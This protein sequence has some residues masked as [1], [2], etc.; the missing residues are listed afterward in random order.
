M[1]TTQ[2]GLGYYGV[3]PEPKSVTDNDRLATKLVFDRV[4][5]ARVTPT[6]DRS[7]QGNSSSGS[8]SNSK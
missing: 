7:S 3:A 2:I 5:R 8:T 6:D 1:G 4:F